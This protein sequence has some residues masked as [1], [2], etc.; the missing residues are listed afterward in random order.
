MSSV[1]NPHALAPR[2]GMSLGA[3]GMGRPGRPGFARSLESPS[4]SL[5]TGASYEEHLRACAVPPIAFQGT[6]VY[7]S[8]IEGLAGRMDVA[9][10]V[11]RWPGQGHATVIYHP[12]ANERPFEAHCGGV[13]TFR[14]IFLDERE[15]VQANLIVVRAAFH[16]GPSRTYFRAMGDMAAF[17]ALLCASAALTEALVSYVKASTQGRVV[18]AGLSLGGGVTNVHR[19]FFNSVPPGGT[20]GRGHRRHVHRLGVPAAHGE[21]STTQ[22]GRGPARAQPTRSVAQNPDAK[23]LS[24]AGAPRPHHTL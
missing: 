6:G 20:R 19:A 21:V 4:T 1:F 23:R 15:P 13:N 9:Y 14:R 3:L 24:P 11:A 7:E 2:G 18:V 12:G 8:P 5:R 22:A 17:M 10:C 16:T